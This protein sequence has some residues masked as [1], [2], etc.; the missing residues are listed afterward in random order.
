MDR[1]SLVSRSIGSFTIDVVTAEMHES[2]LTLTENPIESG[3][4]IA[5]HAILQPR[6]LTII[7]TMV[8]YEP[9]KA[10]EEALAGYGV[11]VADLPLPIE[12]SA[13]TSQ[14]LSA[15]NRY[16]AV[17]DESKERIDRAIAAWLPDYVTYSNDE[18]ETLDRVGKARNQLLQLQRSGETIDIVTGLAKYSNMM[19][20]SVGVFQQY[21]GSAEFTITA[22]EVFIVESKKGSGLKV[23]TTRAS[24]QSAGKKNN[25]K[26]QPKEDKSALD[27]LAGGIRNVFN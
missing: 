18:S 17:I 26:T 19:I 22:R 3:A 11:N 14:A 10:M 2:E 4:N 6:Q 1:Y 9:K 16:M 5:D 21:D 7:G 25:G 23:K 15:A 27:I 20:T 12:L 13:V 24:Q 8:G